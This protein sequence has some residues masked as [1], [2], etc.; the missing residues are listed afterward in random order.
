MKKTA[1]KSLTLLIVLTFLFEM[2]SSITQLRSVRAETAAAK[3]SVN[4]IY[5]SA[6]E[7]LYGDDTSGQE[8]TSYLE[9][10][11]TSNTE[12]IV[13][14]VFANMINSRMTPDIEEDDGGTAIPSLQEYPVEKHD[15]SYYGDS[16]RV[17]FAD[18]NDHDAGYF[19]YR[20]SFF[21]VSTEESDNYVVEYN[22]EM[23]EARISPAIPEEW[24]GEKTGIVFLKESVAEDIILVFEEKPVT[25]DGTMTV[26]L[27]N[28]D[29]ITLNMI[30]SDGKLEAENR[31]RLRAGISYEDE[32]SGTNWAGKLTGVRFKDIGGVS[33][34]DFW[35]FLFVLNVNIK[36]EV[37][38]DITTTGPTP[39]RESAQA[40]KVGFSV[41]YFDIDFIYYI[42]VEF[43][44]APLHVTGSMT[45]DFVY[46]L[47]TLGS[48]IRR[49]RNPVVLKTL[50]F[51]GNNSQNRHVGFYI[52]SQFTCRGGFLSFSID[53]LFIHKSIG[54]VLSLNLDFRAGCRFVAEHQT[55]RF[56]W[57]DQSLDELH[58]CV[59]NGA[60]GCLYLSSAESYATAL[61]FRIDLYFKHWDFDLI[62]G[63]ETVIE[64]KKYHQSYTYDG[65]DGNIVEGEC[66]HQFYRV[67]VSVWLD[68]EMTLPAPA[69]NVSPSDHV[70]PSGDLERSIVTATT[71]SDGKASIYLPYI[72]NYRYTLVAV[73]EVEG[74]R[75]KGASIQPSN[76]VRRLN[77]NVDIVLKAGDEKITIHV[78]N[79]WIVDFKENDRPQNVTVAL[80]R[81]INGAWEQAATAELNGENGWSTDFTAAKF[82]VTDGEVR[83]V[84]YRVVLLDENSA[85]VEDRQYA[86]FYVDRYISVS[87]E[88]E[89]THRTKYYVEYSSDISNTGINV[90][91]TETAVADVSI[92]KLWSIDDE[93]ERPGSVYL[94]LLWKPEE[95]W[96][97]N[98]AALHVPNAWV[99]VLKP[100]AGDTS[101]LKSLV[102]ASII[103]TEDISGIENVPV[104]IGKFSEENEWSIVYTVPKYKNGIKMQF[105]AY[106]LDSSVISD[107]LLYEYDTKMKVSAVQSDKYRSIPAK[108]VRGSE[109][110]EY[111][112]SLLNIA[113]DDNTIGGTVTWV[114]D[115]QYD[116][117]TRMP[118]KSEWVKI[119]IFKDGSELSNSPVV[120]Y[121]STFEPNID[122]YNT[123]SDSEDY[124]VV[125]PWSLSGPNIDKNAEYTI[126]EELS[127]RQTF[128]DRWSTTVSG[129]NAVNYWQ[130]SNNVFVR[131]QCIFEDMIT[132][133]D[134][135]QIML[136]ITPNG[137]PTYSYWLN[138]ENNF[139]S[140]EVLFT[141]RD[142][143][144]PGFTI[145]VEN[146][147]V[148]F[149]RI[150]KD[151]VVTKKPDGTLIYNYTVVFLNQCYLEITVSKSWD[152]NGDT[153]GMK[154]P[155]FDPIR[156]G[157]YRDG[158]LIGNVVLNKKT[159]Y[160]DNEWES[161]KITTDSEG[162]KLYRIAP[163]GH[164]YEYT[165]IEEP[166]T[167]FSSVVTVT[168][169]SMSQLTADLK[170]IWVGPDWVDVMGT[171][172]WIGDSDKKYL[173]PDTVHISVVNSKGE[174]VN[175]LDAPVNGNSW[176]LRYVPGTDE[177]GEPLSYSVLQSHV[178][179]YSTKNKAP[180]YDQ[181]YRAWRCDTE[182]TLTGY[183]A[184]T[185]EKVIEGGADDEDKQEQFVFEIESRDDAVDADH[186][187]P[188]PVKN[189]VSI[190]GEGSTVAEFLLD[191]DGVYLYSIKEKK[192]TN[193]NCVYDD[194]ENLIL[195]VRVSDDNGNTSFR[196]WVGKPSENL[197]SGENG[198]EGNGSQNAQLTAETESDKVSF[199]NKY[200][201]LKIK[202]DWEID[203]EGKDRPDSIEV[204]LQAKKEGGWETEKIIE[205]NGD[206]D[207]SANVKLSGE[208]NGKTEYRVRELKEETA[209]MELIKKIRDTVGEFVS[210][211]YDSWISGIKELAGGYYEKL[212]SS[213]KDAADQGLEK[214]KEKLGATEENLLDKL[215]EQ[216][217]IASAIDR[218]VY[219]EEDG[220][221]P[222]EDA[223]TNEV[224]YHVSGYFSAISGGNEDAHVTKYKVSYDEEEG[225]FTVTN[226]AIIDIDL[227]KR[228]ITVNG[229]GI[230][231]KP[232][233]EDVPD[234]AWLVLMCSPKAGALDG[235]AELAGQLGIDLG[236]VLDYEFPVINPV[237]GGRDPISIISELALGVDISIFGKLKI[238]PKLAIARVTEEDSWTKRMVVKKYN[239]GIP[240]EYKGA[241]LGSEIIRQI[242]KYLINISLPV[243]YNPFDNYFSIPTKA[244][245]TVAGITDPEDFLD[246]S[247]LSG[248]L[249]EK[250]KSLTLDNVKNFG[251]KTLLDDWHLM[252]N[253]INIKID[254]D[255]DED[256][257]RVS[258]VKIWDDAGNEDKRPEWIKI[259][260][261]DGEGELEDSPVLLKKSDYENINEWEWSLELPDDYDG[262]GEFRVT[263]EYPENYEYK[264]SY[265]V[266]T[267]DTDITN[268]WS[269]DVMLVSGRKIWQDEDDM[270]GIRPETVTV[271]LKADGLE[272]GRATTSAEG[273]WKFFFS[274][275]PR[276]NK[277]GETISYT[278]EE[279]LTPVITGEDGPGTYAVKVEEYNIV[280]THTPRSGALVIVKAG[281]VDDNDSFVFSITRKDDSDY[282]LFVTIHGNGSVRI[283]NVKPGEY[284]VK[285][286]TDWSW[287]YREDVSVSAS[288]AESFE[289]WIKV[290]GV[291]KDSPVPTLTFT[292]EPNGK[293]W[294]SSETYSDSM[295]DPLENTT[296]Q[297]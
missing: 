69:S 178:P 259:H 187:F 68:E 13:G 266:A 94:A 267:D 145:Y 3:R 181:S 184:A 252:A 228:W 203:I 9:A 70:A 52:G 136:R 128:H 32:I 243:S 202:K 189:Q 121:R 277:D 55:D 28:T 120:L 80:Q 63:T 6:D 105:M 74:G 81:Y 257:D 119:H 283:T 241:E 140:Q 24:L 250:A 169:T 76:I 45:T 279:L 29:D 133:P 180:Y 134:D 122:P 159:P 103:T 225:S 174:L 19:V 18:E 73:K 130:G 142:D 43:P 64:Q 293:N 72:A 106:E 42:Q 207:W 218:I 82:I 294:L 147:S 127:E 26:P 137:E 236:S 50:E 195:I 39:E 35:D 135:E 95:N 14:D 118:L 191:D 116:M 258:G 27:K 219:D 61:R 172:T 193:G 199:T 208:N 66:P 83:L 234:A 295:F 173:R 245:R 33:D 282:E 270:D 10:N 268:T 176:I 242:I 290:I 194:S 200:P 30:F 41:K 67:P 7:S 25:K 165:L 276:K 239:V 141:F 231:L 214:L 100:L 154:Y 264:D 179:G 235:A 230:S 1:K 210:G 253:V 221:K 23:T 115:R 2:C 188:D 265:S 232:D 11:A 89:P 284:L 254:W 271:I 201:V 196:S 148:Y 248:K 78:D 286:I 48:V 143:D 211:Q 244:I 285:E 144:V 129:L 291:S 261:S 162:N 37:D 91:I 111:T 160:H 216:L 31:P 62:G 40:A 149:E 296:I 108:A 251:P 175:T 46:S 36:I 150:Y 112:A 185:I 292:N 272:A 222:S 21:L 247:A 90:L 113:N 155:P 109:D 161:V 84:A 114:W 88:A 237:E 96:H 97:N 57:P 54:P 280:N 168:E 8:Y 167:G 183:F 226:T 102:D 126:T 233:G 59:I 177:N 47:G 152:N 278:I 138:K 99:A 204:V 220:D 125:W 274:N 269:P 171:V 153:E 224:R 158:E 217:G 75:I 229:D 56:S 34:V 107:L 22:E 123:Y 77:D 132:L 93:T 273:E 281:A 151:P 297:P 166:V 53:F 275:L 49:Y 262:D 98:A 246:F 110:W 146:P 156:A 117:Y 139:S 60:P 212:P 87:D 238:V 198:D 51:L 124:S 17:R 131:V 157:L 213:L 240:M 182:N 227:I 215:V 249:L 163:D 197:T 223:V 164:K 5:R 38:F 4:G 86:A 79:R 170:N 255:T 289:D 92:Y 287:K 15:V 12:N 101:T 65:A 260:V 44:S 71:G 256:P 186:D 85:A 288:N 190:T 205:L 209:L 263:E 58:T 104:A 20:D 206:N 16:P 192:G